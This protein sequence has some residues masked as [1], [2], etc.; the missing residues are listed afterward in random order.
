MQAEHALPED[1]TR[2]LRAG[3]R[4]KAIALLRAH[5]SIATEEAEAQIER[6][7]EDNPPIPLRGPGVVA[8]SR[9]NALVW[10]TLILLMG[11][12]YWLLSG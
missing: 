9:L 4:Q 8:S 11:L 10:L 2:A 6:Y 7:L 3:Q 1:V 5:R 12:A